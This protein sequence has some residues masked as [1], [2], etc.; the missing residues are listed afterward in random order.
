MG[1]AHVE[2]RM[3]GRKTRSEA[4]WRI[5]ARETMRTTIAQVSPGCQC[6]P[7]PCNGVLQKT[8]VS[9]LAGICRRLFLNKMATVIMSDVISLAWQP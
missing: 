5:D 6:L 3:R 4:D 8:P 9:R 1:G 2:F 7:C